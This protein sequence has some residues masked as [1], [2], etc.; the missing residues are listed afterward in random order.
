VLLPAAGGLRVLSDL[1]HEG[2]TG[3]P[4]VTN[5][6]E[7]TRPAIAYAAKPASPELFEGGLAEPVG[8]GG[9]TGRV[10]DWQP[11]QTPQQLGWSPGQAILNDTGARQPEHTF[12]QPVPVVARIV[13]E[14]DGEEFIETV[15]AGWSGQN[16]RGYRTGGTDLPRCGSTRRTSPGNR[17]PRKGAID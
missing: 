12:Y 15:A 11:P 14:G 10:G 7:T 4:A 5:V 1:E 6:A 9:D 3:E 16:V 13:W 8:P 2:G 17:R